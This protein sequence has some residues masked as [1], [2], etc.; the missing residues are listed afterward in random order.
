MNWL[1]AETRGN[2]NTI[3]VSQCRAGCLQRYRARLDGAPGNTSAKPLLGPRICGIRIT[4]HLPETEYIAVKE[5]DLANELR[6]F[7]GVALWNND[8][9]WPSVFLGQRL[10]IPF[11]C[12][13]P[14]VIHADI[15]RIVRRVT[16]VA[17][18]EHV[19]G[20]GLRLHQVCDGK[21]GH[22]FPF[23]V[24]LA[25][26]GDTMKVARVLELRKRA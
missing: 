11:V 15:E 9:G 6:A 20:L 5:D 8:T 23:H 12:D 21:K 17:F 25:P 3:E 22:A 14:V 26:G 4:S 1:R 10:V 24:E 16:V 19:R 2:T 18:E 13:Q 7:P